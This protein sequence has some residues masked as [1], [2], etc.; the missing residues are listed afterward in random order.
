MVHVRKQAV[1]RTVASGA[2]TEFYL[3]TLKLKGLNKGKPAWVRV[4]GNWFVIK[5][6][7]KKSATQSKIEKLEAQLA[8]LRDKS[9]PAKVNGGGHK[10]WAGKSPEEIKLHMD[11]MREAAKKKREA[12]HGKQD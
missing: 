11:K 12:H 7:A 9:G 4:R 8:V 2:V 3:T 1:D 5:P 10:R 6:A